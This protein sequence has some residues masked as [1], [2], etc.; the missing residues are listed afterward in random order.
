M[1]NAGVLRSMTGR[2]WLA[3]IAG[4]FL[5]AFFLAACHQPPGDCAN[6]AAGT[7]LSNCDFSGAALNGIDLNGANL[8]NADFTD[9]ALTGI[10]LDGANLT[11]ADFTDAKLTNANLRGADVTGAHFAGADFRLLRSGNIT[12]EPA[13]LPTDFALVQGDDPTSTFGHFMGPVADLSNV[14][15]NASNCE[16]CSFDGL[17]LDAARFRGATFQAT[18]TNS[19]MKGADVRNADLRGF[20][21][22]N[23]DFTATSFA[24][25]DLGPIE[26]CPGSNGASFVFTNLTRVTFR[27]T[28]LCETTIAWSIVDRTSFGTTTMTDEA[29]S[30]NV[31]NVGVPARLAP[32]WT[33]VGGVLAPPP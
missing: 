25:S 3:R 32:G 13:S 19:T 11:N 14:V 12:T 2:R 4:L 18:L 6:P 29:P 16:V 9:A 7:D 17:D 23:V 21:A 22:G 8:T 30:N 1:L 10:D 20:S 27:D 5:G 15:V 24:E 26:G 31:G 28:L 33:F